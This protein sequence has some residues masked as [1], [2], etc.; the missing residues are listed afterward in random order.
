M[1]TLIYLNVGTAIV[2]F[3]F[4]TTHKKTSGPAARLQ[5]GPEVGK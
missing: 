5:H 4:S 3:T 2:L 1:L